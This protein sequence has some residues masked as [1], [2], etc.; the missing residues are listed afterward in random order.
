MARDKGVRRR[1]HT[2]IHSERLWRMDMG[3]GGIRRS[4]QAKEDRGMDMGKRRDKDNT[5]RALATGK[6]VIMPRRSI[7]C[8]EW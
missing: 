6:E 3:W 2:G 5:C 4:T 7:Q 1:A 8:L